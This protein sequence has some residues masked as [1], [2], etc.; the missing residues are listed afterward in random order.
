MYSSTNI[1]QMRESAKKLTYMQ[2]GQYMQQMQ[3]KDIEAAGMKTRH[4]TSASYILKTHS[5][6]YL[7][8]IT[9]DILQTLSRTFSKRTSNIL[10]DMPLK[11]HR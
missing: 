2:H 5:R 1:A 3:A 6:R 7:K 9:Q 8:D 4:C 10:Q 11:G